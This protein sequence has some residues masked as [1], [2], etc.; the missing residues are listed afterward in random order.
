M[1]SAIK[2]PIEIEDVSS[3]EEPM[4]DPADGFV[5]LTKEGL[6]IGLTKALA[7]DAPFSASTSATAPRAELECRVHSLT[8]ERD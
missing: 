3:G 6:L 4:E 1:A 2:G 5:E 8:F 7:E